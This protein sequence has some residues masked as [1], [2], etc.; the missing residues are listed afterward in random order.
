MNNPRK[1]IASNAELFAH[2]L[3]EKD[4]TLDSG[5]G[6]TVRIRELSGA[7]RFEL[8]ERQGESRWPLLVWVVSRGLVDPE[9]SG[10]EDVEKMKPEWVVDIA[11]AIT[12]MSGMSDDEDEDESGNE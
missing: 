2:E 12:D 9:P 4:Y 3:E 7:E 1:K 8:V 10:I 11:T 6:P 5:K